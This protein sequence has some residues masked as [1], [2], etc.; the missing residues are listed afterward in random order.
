MS[1]TK[2]EQTGEY[3]FKNG[4]LRREDVLQHTNIGTLQKASF[5]GVEIGDEALCGYR[6][7]E[8]FIFLGKLKII[9]YYAFRCCNIKKIEL[10]P[11]TEYI[12]D[13]AFVGCSKLVDI[14]INNMDNLTLGY[15][16]FGIFS[17]LSYPEERTFHLGEIDNIDKGNSL[18]SLNN[19]RRYATYQVP[20][21]DI[22]IELHYPGG[23]IIAEPI[24]TKSVLYMRLE[25]FPPTI[26][27]YHYRG[28]AI[29]ITLVSLD[30]NEFIVSCD[31]KS[32]F[33]KQAKN[34]HPETLSESW[35]IYFPWEKELVKKVDYSMILHKV[36]Q[37]EWDFGKSLM[38]T[39]D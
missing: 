31:F 4:I 35:S 7:L 25:K 18:L 17:V 33:I 11:S 38:I 24:K 8:E 34:Q 16:V 20:N 1:K 27:T 23:D 5:S 2:N 10:P 29:Q 13:L 15:R 22:I 26:P 6:Y 12:D 28:K 21:S 32:D 36:I 19:D 39:W 30:G 37:K 9:G 14:R 3:H